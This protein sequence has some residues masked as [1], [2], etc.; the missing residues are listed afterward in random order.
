MDVVGRDI[1]GY[2]A[3]AKRMVESSVHLPPGYHIV[4]GGQYEYRQ[5]ARERMKLVIPATLGLIFL[6]LYCNFKSVAESLSVMLSLPFALVGGIWFMWLLSYNMSVAVAIGFIALAGEYAGALES[7]VS[8]L[9]LGLAEPGEFL[10]P[11]AEAGK[12][13]AFLDELVHRDLGEQLGQQVL[14]FRIV[15]Q[16]GHR[17][18]AEPEQ[19][20]AGERVLIVFDAL[21]EVL[22]VPLAQRGQRPHLPGPFG[23][24]PLLQFG[25]RQHEGLS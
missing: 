21:E 25:L 24:G 1:G 23:P 16:L 6:L 20:F 14:P 19:L 7:P 5:R 10:A 15:L 4:W 17:V 18:V 12:P 3:D 2:V 22:L 11:A 8:R 9:P 13:E